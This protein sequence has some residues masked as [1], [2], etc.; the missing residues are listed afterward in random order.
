[1]AA[2]ATWPRPTMVTDVHSFLGFTN[3]YRRLIHR[4]AQTAD[5]LNALAAVEYA[6]KKK[7]TVEWYLECEK[8]FSELKEHTY[9]GICRLL[10]AV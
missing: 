1:M 4:Y 10:Q 7:K 6:N 9:S 8:A 2:I 5:P 3:H